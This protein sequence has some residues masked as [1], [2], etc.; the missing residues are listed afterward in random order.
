MMVENDGNPAGKVVTVTRGDQF[1]QFVMHPG[2]SVLIGRG[3]DCDVTLPYR[4]VSVH[5]AL[6]RYRPLGD[7]EPVMHLE[8]TSTNGTG[9]ASGPDWLPIRKGQ[10]RALKSLGKFVVPF[11]R[12]PHQEAVVLTVINHG[13]GLPDAYDSKRKSGRWKYCGKLG[14]GGLGVVYRAVDALGR[15]QGD[16]AIKVCKLAKNIKAAAKLRSAFKLHREA[17]WSL[18]LIHNSMHKSYSQQRAGLFARYL[19]DHTG[20]WSTDSNFDA[21]RSTFEAANFR[22]D[23][24]EP[25]SPLP[26]YPYVAMEFVP[27]RTVH[28]ALGWSR[29]HPLKDEAVLT[30]KERESIIRQA[31]QALIY[32]IEMG[33]IHRDFRTTNLMVV[34]RNSS[35]EMRVIDLGLAISS[36]EHQCQNESAVVRCNWKEE[37]KHGFDWAPPEVKAKEP[38]VNFLYPM[39]SFDVFSFGVLAVQLQTNGA[40]AARLEVSRLMG[41]DQGEKL[42]GKMG[43]SQQMLI[44]MLGEASGRPHAI[45]LWEHLKTGQQRPQGQPKETTPYKVSQNLSSLPNGKTGKICR[46]EPEVARN[47]E[48]G[49]SLASSKRLP[50]HHE[51]PTKRQRVSQ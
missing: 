38:F 49:A 26:S 37:E 33:L 13:E 22:W 40:Q 7:S 2:R 18:Q 21:E 30:H 8:D 23:K 36:E 45:E 6:L 20:H 16:I 12:K 35:I 14:E 46:K 3:S 34:R 48:H 9:M 29:H 39:H 25:P 32:L 17:Q 51:E 28:S 11:N 47:E 5:H 50:E 15:L 10:A 27:G 1:W 31:T 24:F 44:R 4:G 43:F 42:V 41:N 19:E